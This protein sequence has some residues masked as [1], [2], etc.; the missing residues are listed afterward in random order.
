MDPVPALG[1]HTAAVLGE[2]GIPEAEL[3]ELRARGVIAC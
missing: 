1:V 3:A 2:L